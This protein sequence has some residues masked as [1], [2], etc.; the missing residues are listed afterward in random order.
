MDMTGEAAEIHMRTD[1]NNLV[2]TSRTTHLPEQKESIHM[3]QMLRQEACSGNIDD[4]AHMLT[5]HML[6]DCLTKNSVKPDNLI[7]AIDTG[8]LL[9][10]DKHPPFRELLKDRHKAYQCFA[11]WVIKNLKGAADIVTVLG[12]FVQKDI[13]ATLY[14]EAGIMPGR[15]IHVS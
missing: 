2:T 3:I 13:H 1:A 12:E 10:V 7:K 5:Q 14:Q 6:A 9:E 8:V 4:L 11:N 15:R